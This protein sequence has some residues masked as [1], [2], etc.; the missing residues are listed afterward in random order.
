MINFKGGTAKTTTAVFMAHALV[1]HGLRVLLV[2]A[3]PQG[4]A[5]RWN[6]YAGGFP[7][8]VAPLATPGLHK[9]LPG[10]AGDRFEVVVIDTPP[11][12]DQRRIVLGALQAATDALVPMAPTP[13]ECER[14]G[15]VREAVEQAADLRRDSRYPRVA[16]VLTRTVAGA[17]SAGVWRDYLT[18][19]GDRVLKV[20]VGRLERFAQAYGQPIHG[21]SSGAYGDVI[22]EL[23]LLEGTRS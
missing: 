3:D 10:V 12:D 18:E 23:R 15:A 6:D 19:A 4:S 21:A 14:M 5:Q 22:R 1:E 9:R 2:D 8:P 20:Q 11:V 16:V 17:S 7:F 13:A